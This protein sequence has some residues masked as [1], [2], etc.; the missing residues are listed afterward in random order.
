MALLCLGIAGCDNGGPS[1]PTNPS[2]SPATTTRV[3]GIAGN[4]AFGDVM[5]GERREATMTVTNSGNA[6]LT[7]TGMNITGGLEQHMTASWTSGPVSAGGSQSVT[8]SFQ[9]AAPG[10][11]TGT[12][13][14]LGDMTSGTN[15][16]NVSGNGLPST[17]YAGLWSGNYIVEQCNGTG[18]LQDL[19]CSS[20]RGA[21]PVGSSLPIAMD[22]T[23]SGSAVSG[24]IALGQVRGVANGI[25]NSTGF[26]V[27]QGT[28]TS[29]QLTAQIT[30][31]STRAQGNVMEGTF[32]YNATIS[33]T[34]GVAVVV[35]RLG[36]V[37]K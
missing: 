9:P 36:T 29:G 16:I 23:Q 26:L 37:T 12:L 31:W 22:L 14:I 24:T 15:T 8:I 27:L 13:T 19:L 1:L 10:T 34:P 4:L 21:F 18:S 2:P 6:T 11:Y 32:T 33:G 7:V 28:A 30:S 20:A 25:V 17:P 35:T 3:I 5:V